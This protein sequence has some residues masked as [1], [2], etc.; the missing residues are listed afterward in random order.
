MKFFLKL[1]KNKFFLLF[2]LFLFYSFVL[3][4]S[5]L[6]FIINKKREIKSLNTQIKKT[7][8]KLDSI[9]KN[10]KQLESKEGIEK[11]AREKKFFKK[12]DEEIFVITYE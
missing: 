9:K 11:Y 12:S 7:N 2:F 3:S 8:I 1:F 6:F 5:D 4:D 10:L